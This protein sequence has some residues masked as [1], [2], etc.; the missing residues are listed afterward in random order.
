MTLPYSPVDSESKE[1]ELASL[2]SESDSESLLSIRESRGKSRRKTGIPKGNG[3]KAVPFHSLQN[4]LH[5]NVALLC[6]PTV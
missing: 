2:L 6:M 5:C 1:S 4:F 3:R